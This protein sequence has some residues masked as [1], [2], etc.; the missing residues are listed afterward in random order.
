MARLM[1]QQPS[2]FSPVAM[3]TTEIIGSVDSVEAPFK[4]HADDATNGAVH[5][6][7][8]DLRVAWLIPVVES[9]AYRA[10]HPLTSSK[11]PP[12]IFGGCREWVLNHNSAALLE[13]TYDVVSVRAV[14]GTDDQRLHPLL[15]HHPIEAVGVVRWHVQPEA[16]LQQPPMVG[17]ACAVDI[18]QANDYCIRVVAGRQC[19]SIERRAR[20]STH[21]RIAAG[22]LA[23]CVV[24]AVRSQC[25]YP[26]VGCMIAGKIRSCLSVCLSG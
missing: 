12:H 15:C 18:A 7:P 16:F 21:E 6:Q 2:R 26:L 10:V 14:D 19:M 1:H 20:T 9:D 17:Q 8:L 4:M 3:P 24:Y 22:H 5:E 11:D 25:D 13:S 23:L